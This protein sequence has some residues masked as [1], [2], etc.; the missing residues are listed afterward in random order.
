MSEL[1]N[2]N[3]NTNINNINNKSNLNNTKKIEGNLDKKIKNDFTKI[4][5]GNSSNNISSLHESNSNF[6]LLN[7]QNNLNIHNNNSIN[8]KI[9]SKLKSSQIK[10]TN[11]KS[12]NLILDTSD[13]S[14]LY[15]INFTEN[16]CGNYFENYLSL[17]KKPMENKK[18]TNI[19][20]NKKININ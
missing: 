6:K 18:N 20:T 1:I 9:I 13:N 19:N 7:S 5:I 8:N 16:N 2:K 15:N 14:G 4:K 10:D 11:N 12:R 3:Q 17:N